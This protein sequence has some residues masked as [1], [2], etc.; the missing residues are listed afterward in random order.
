MQA[1]FPF[2]LLFIQLKESYF[3]KKKGKTGRIQK[4]MKKLG[5][6]GNDMQQQ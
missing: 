3:T 5:L 2:L 1:P 4:T 6:E